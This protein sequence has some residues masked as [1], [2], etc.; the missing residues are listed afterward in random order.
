MITQQTYSRKANAR[1]AAQADLGKHAVEGQDYR[2]QRL[3]T[4]RYTYGPTTRD[5]GEAG[6]KG[7]TPPAKAQRAA[8]RADKCDK[9]GLRVGSK[10]AI[11]AAMLERGCTMA[12][13]KKATGGTR[14]N[15]LR[16]LCDDG[17]EIIRGPGA[18]IGLRHNP[19]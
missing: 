13:I 1:R 11:A 6:P 5:K 7:A 12:D 16:K 14:Y 15:L 17:H 4:G 9:F 18:Q 10:G 2:I 19:S 3:A 8:V